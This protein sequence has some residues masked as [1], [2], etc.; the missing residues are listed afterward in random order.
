MAAQSPGSGCVASMLV[1]VSEALLAA[2]TRPGWK[3]AA[4]AKTAGIAVY[5][6]MD[7]SS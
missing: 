2:A 6:N 3:N 1:R 7:F 5:F 4:I